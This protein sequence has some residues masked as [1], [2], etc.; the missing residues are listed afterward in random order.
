MWALIFN[1]LN[2]ENYNS[3]SQKHFGIHNNF[4]T[5]KMSWDKKVVNH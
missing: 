1:L 5:V 2:E 4:K 3:P